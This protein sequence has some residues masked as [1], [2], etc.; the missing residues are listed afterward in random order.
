VS[1]TPA[2]RQIPGFEKIIET[3]RCKNPSR[4][5]TQP[6]Y[7]ERTIAAV[8]HPATYWLTRDVLHVDHGENIVG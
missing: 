8:C 2:L 6:E 7:V 5:L 1:D 4:R 3:A